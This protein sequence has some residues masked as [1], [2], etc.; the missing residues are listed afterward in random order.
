[1]LRWLWLVPALVAA[2]SL[3]GCGGSNAMLAVGEG[4]G[5]IAADDFDPFGA[6]GGPVNLKYFTLPAS[7]TFQLILTSGPGQPALPN[8]QIM[9]LPGHVLATNVSFLGAYDSGAGVVTQNHASTIAQVFIT[10]AAGQEFTFA[11][12]SWNGGAG[13]YSWRVMQ[14]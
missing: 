10:A 13:R 11:F 8:P 7:G 2:L 6:E 9:V 1:M 5:V 12:S 3:S 14:L 4:S